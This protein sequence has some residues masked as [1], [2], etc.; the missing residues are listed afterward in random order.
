MLTGQYE[1]FNLSPVQP[2]Y[3]DASEIYLRYSFQY[4]GCPSILDSIATEVLNDTIIQLSIYHKF[5]G[6]L[7][8]CGGDRIFSIGKLP[9]SEYKLLYSVYAYVANPHNSQASDTLTIEIERSLAPDYQHI[10]EF[11]PLHEPFEWNKPVKLRY[12]YAFPNSSCKK[13]SMRLNIKKPHNSIQVD[14]FYGIGDATMPCA[15]YDT[16]N[17]GYLAPGDYILDLNLV[18][19]D[20]GY[21]DS[22][23]IPFQVSNLPESIFEM[24]TAKESYDTTET[25]FLAYQYGFP[26][27]PCARDSVTSTFMN[28]STL[29]IDAYYSLGDTITP[30][31]GYDSVEIG[32]LAAG[33]YTLYFN[34]HS[35]GQVFDDKDTL[36]FIVDLGTAVVDNILLQNIK[37]YPNPVEERLNISGFE[38]IVRFEL[39]NISGQRILLK[40]AKDNPI[41]IYAGTL[42][43][44]MYVIKLLLENDVLFVKKIIIQ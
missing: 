33:N 41:T 8:P 10:Y 14:A 28:D 43:K 5:S 7:E 11:S 39:I 42:P 25:V 37:I 12:K 30:C 44:G 15:G 17:L 26:Y 24:R 23:T 22:D 19:N 35:T 20:Y 32:K 40:E 6:Y 13:D 31:T 27:H 16:L 3:N 1:V 29:S 36:R 2:K 34:M 38:R 21:M 4:Y 18:G 9:E